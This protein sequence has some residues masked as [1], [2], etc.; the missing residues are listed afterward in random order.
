MI[1]ALNSTQLVSQKV[2]GLA[3]MG[4]RYP[5]SA[6]DPENPHLPTPEHNFGFH[7]EAT[8]PRCNNISS[9]PIAPSTAFVTEHWPSK[10]PI[11]FLGWE[12]GARILTGAVMTNGSTADNPCRQAYIDHGNGALGWV[13]KYRSSNSIKY[14]QNRSFVVI[15]NK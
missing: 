9:A 14:K 10:V 4:G 12:L 3:W 5:T 8:S 1:S 2:K 15:K 13:V 11:V 6:A 7:C